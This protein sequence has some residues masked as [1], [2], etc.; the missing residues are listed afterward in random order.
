MATFDV[1]F[2]GG[3]AKGIAFAGALEMLFE[4][5]HRLGRVL[6]TSA[7][8][9]TATLCA[10]GFTPADMLAA[11]QERVGG[12]PRFSTF[13]DVPSRG[14]FREDL[15][16]R[17]LLLQML[18]GVDVPLVPEALERRFDRALLHALL[19]NPLYAQLF[20]FVECGGFFAGER[21]LEWIREKLAAKGAGPDDTLLEFHTRTGADLSLVVSDTTD[22]EMLVLNHRTAPGVPVAWAVRMSMSIP[23]VWQEVVWRAEWGPYLGRDKTGNVIVDGGLL[24]NFPMRLIATSDEAVR[25]IMGDVSPSQALNLGLLIDENLPVPGAPPAP[26]LQTALAEFPAVRRV[27]RLV[28]TMMGAWD[29]DMIRRYADQICRLPAKGYGTLEFDMEGRRLDLLLE[30]ARAAMAAHLKSRLL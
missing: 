17:S 28:E 2:E 4:R 18:A 7:G 12:K 6:G 19:A 27:A 24:S 23:F 8:A 20:S 5:G 22:M 3:G 21:F 14:S 1:V 11:V 15:I 25:R 9:I 29:S 30:A 10:A 26:P 16:E 13:L